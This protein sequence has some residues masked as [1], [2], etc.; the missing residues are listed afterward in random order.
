MTTAKQQEAL[1]DARGD[2]GLFSFQETALAAQEEEEYCER[3]GI[4][5][6]LWGRLQGDGCAPEKKGQSR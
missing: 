6:T 2:T 3:V 1:E 5:G 4:R